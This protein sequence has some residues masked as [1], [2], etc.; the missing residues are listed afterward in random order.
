MRTMPR[1]CLLQQQQ[2]QQ[3][4]QQNR[5]RRVRLVVFNAWFQ[6]IYFRLLIYVTFTIFNPFHY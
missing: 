3:Q 6:K 5:S 4:Q 2:Q 1:Q